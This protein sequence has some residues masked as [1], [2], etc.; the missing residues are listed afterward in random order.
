MLAENPSASLVDLGDGVLCAELHSQYQPNLNPLDDDM[1]KLLY[2]ALEIVPQKGFKGLVI[3]SE[4]QNFSAGANLALILKLIDQKEW[5]KI[6]A[7]S[8]GFQDL[9]QALK[10][11]TF[12]VVSAPFNLTLGGGFELAAAADRVVA[13][14]EAYIGAVEVGVGLIPGAGGTLRILLN[15]MEMMKPARLG[16]FPPVQKAFETIAY[17]KVSGSALEARSLGYLRQQDIIIM[18]PDHL[19]YEAKQTVLKLAQGYQPP[20]PNKEIYLPGEGGRL[21][22]ESAIDDLL[23][24]AKITPYDAFIGKKL[25]Y[26]LTGG[27][28]ASPTTP[29]D[30]Q[31]MLDLERKVFVELCQQEKTRERIV[32]MLKTGKPLRN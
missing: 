15:F 22:I 17:A 20:A 23:K 5:E 4:G 14:A 18:N 27:D 24:Q 30:E 6:E 13:C 2:Q 28:E 8:K 3:A 1:L 26:V 32:H 11:A 29:V 16:P 31:Y 9:G 12:P 25:A 10:F 21:V 7:L 19:A